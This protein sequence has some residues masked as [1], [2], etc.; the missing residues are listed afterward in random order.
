MLDTNALLAIHAGAGAMD[1]KDS[2]KYQL[3]EIHEIEEQHT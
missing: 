1:K 3:E 2:S